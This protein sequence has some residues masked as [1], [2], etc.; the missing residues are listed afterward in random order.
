MSNPASFIAREIGAIGPVQ[1]IVNA[2]SSGTDAIGIG[3]SWIRAGICDVVIAG[4]ADELCRTTYNG[5][6]SLMIYD[7]SPCKP[8]DKNRKGLNLGEGAGMLVL[9]SDV[10][11]SLR[12]K[13]ARSYILG[14]GTASDAYHLTAPSPDGKGL[15][16]A[17]V[18]AIEESGLA[19]EDVSFINAHGT[20]TPDNDEVESRVINKLFSDIPFFSTKGFT[21]HTL[22]A[23][24]GI[25]AVFTVGCLEQGRVPVNIGFTSHDPNLPKDPTKEEMKIDCRIA[26]SQSLAFGGQNAVLIMGKRR[27]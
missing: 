18:N 17:I 14:Y 25:E 7:D 8:F 1:T 16:R 10:S 26:V 11:M 19:P 24:G 5:F 3:A 13:E 20:G 9:E 15:K 27:G 4:G 21:G 6:I 12:K 23:A 22:G 2:C